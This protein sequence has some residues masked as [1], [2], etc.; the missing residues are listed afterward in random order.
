MFPFAV[1]VVGL[2]ALIWL[3]LAVVAVKAQKMIKKEH[4]SIGGC[5]R[6]KKKQYSH[7]FD[8]FRNNNNPE[9]K[10]NEDHDKT[11]YMIISI[12]NIKCGI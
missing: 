4:V 5:L 6:C 2:N 11:L 12:D 9:R 7:H 1:V 8:Y 10:C 3:Y